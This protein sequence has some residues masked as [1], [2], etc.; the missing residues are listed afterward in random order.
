MLTEGLTTSRWM[1]SGWLVAE[2]RDTPYDGASRT[3]NPLQERTE[4]RVWQLSADARIATKTG[5]QVTLTAPDIT[6]SAGAFNYRENFSGLGDTSLIV[7]HRLPVRGG[8]NVTLNAGMSI[9]TGKTERPRFGDTLRDGS[10]VPRSRLQRG[11]G[12][13][14]PLAG[15][16]ANRLVS[17][18]LPPGIRVFTSAAARLPLAE[19]EHGLRTGASWEIGG[20]ASRELRQ[21]GFGHNMIAILRAGWLHRE[22]DVFEGTPVLVGGG[23]WITLSPA[24][25]VSFGTWTLQGEIKLPMWRSLDNRQLDSS[26]T[27]QIGIV[28]A[29]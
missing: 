11:S 1:I 24:L 2:D 22:Q 9:P 20:G 14:D 5:V 29:F 8:W 12:T 26:R 16:S 27:F 10:L 4:I 17:S 18:I 28:K 3:D 13:W 21:S 15:V 19:N 25:A 6:R 23:D 7:W